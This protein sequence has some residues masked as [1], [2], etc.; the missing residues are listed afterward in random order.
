MIEAPN[1]LSARTLSDLATIPEM[2][3]WYGVEFFA[4]WGLV[5][6]MRRRRYE[7]AYG[8]LIVAGVGL[9]L[10][11]FEGNAGTLLRHRAMMI[12]WVAVLAAVGG[13]DFWNRVRARR[14]EVKL[15]SLQ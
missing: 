13:S 10:S 11:L 2:L 9:V 6:L 5:L 15:E 3:M 14:V 1:P 12:P 8:L 4:I 7:F